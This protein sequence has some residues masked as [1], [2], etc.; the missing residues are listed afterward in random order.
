MSKTTRKALLGHPSVV[1]A[2]RELGRVFLCCAESGWRRLREVIDQEKRQ[3][4]SLVTHAIIILTRV[5]LHRSVRWREMAQDHWHWFYINHLPSPPRMITAASHSL[6]NL[7]S[8]PPPKL[9]LNLLVF[10]DHSFVKYSQNT[11]L[12]KYAWK[13]GTEN[14]SNETSWQSKYRLGSVPVTERT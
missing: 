14:V 6:G 7:S 13:G 8:L 12:Q 3:V 2:H 4:F 9:P 10:C 1:G 11:K 5:Y